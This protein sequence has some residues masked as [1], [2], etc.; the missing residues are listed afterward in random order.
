MTGTWRRWRS[1]GRCTWNGKG[2]EMLFDAANGVVPT[3]NGVV[4]SGAWA[5]ARAAEP[6]TNGRGAAP[7]SAAIAGVASSSIP[8]VATMP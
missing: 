6:V 1:G 8:S 2:F 7:L 4:V 3:T 5:L